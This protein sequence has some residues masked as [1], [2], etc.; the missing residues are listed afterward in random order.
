M[1][2]L[3][4]FPN[5]FQ[6]IMALILLGICLAF[7]GTPMVLRKRSFTALT[8][9]QWAALGHVLSGLLWTLIQINLWESKN[10]LH[11]HDYLGISLELGFS[12]LFTI[13]VL[14]FLESV[15][16][17]STHAD[18]LI[19]L[20]YLFSVSITVILISAFPSGEMEMM[21]VL[22]GNLLSITMIEMKIVFI[23]SAIGLS[24]FCLNN[25]II[26][27]SLSDPIGSQFIHPNSK[28]HQVIYQVITSILIVIGIWVLGVIP[29]VSFLLLPSFIFLRLTGSIKYWWI[30][31]TI[32]IC[33]VSYVG[34]T[35]AVYLDI[36]PGPSIATLL[37]AIGLLSFYYKV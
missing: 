15:K 28:M 22:F 16:T 7:Y 24:Y 37:A 18:S 4:D 1:W 21:S 17:R 19:A 30:L 2:I 34:M 32:L 10:E 14:V 12:I 35:I 25:K 3:F 33:M 36:P 11:R 29:V 23:V 27:A 9:P 13:L 6:I 31:G 26:L 8:L 5:L 20:S